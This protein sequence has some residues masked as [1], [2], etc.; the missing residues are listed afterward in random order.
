MVKMQ[1]IGRSAGKLL[2]IEKINGESSETKWK[3]AN[4]IRL[5]YSPAFSE[6]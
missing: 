5:R 2:K 4:Y 3:W 1:G 6:N